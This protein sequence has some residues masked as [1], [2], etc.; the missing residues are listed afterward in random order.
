MAS[1]VQCNKPLVWVP[2]QGPL[3][4]GKILAVSGEQ[5]EFPENQETPDDLW[6]SCGCH[7][8]WDCLFDEAEDI[9]LSLKCPV[10]DTH[11]ATNEPGPSAT[12]PVHHMNQ[13]ITVLASYTSQ[14]G[15]QPNI[16]LLPDLTEESYMKS[17]PEV[18]EARALFIMAKNNQVVDMMELLAQAPHEAEDSVTLGLNNLLR[19]QN[20]LEENKSLLHVAIEQG[21]QDTFYILL[22]LASQLPDDAFPRSVHVATQQSGM[23]RPPHRPHPDIRSLRDSNGETAEDYARKQGGNLEWLAETGLFTPAKEAAEASG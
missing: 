2:F 12:N 6:L 3:R 23:T 8:H 20:P 16:D 14:H 10:C 18:V 1:C 19:F 15:V 22:F 9:V 11:L 13:G 21:H 7:W 17:H 5:P 4:T